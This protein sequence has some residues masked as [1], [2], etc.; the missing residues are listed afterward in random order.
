MQEICK[1]ACV[2]K[3]LLVLYL[4][5]PEPPA[6][7]TLGAVPV[8]AAAAC[9][10]LAELSLAEMDLQAAAHRFHKEC[11]SLVS[12]ALAVVGVPGRRDGL[13]YLPDR[14]EPDAS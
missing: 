8:G 3:I 11:P 4:D 7:G 9:P 2:E 13:E 6:P 5:Q 12:G 10:S 14:E 1:C